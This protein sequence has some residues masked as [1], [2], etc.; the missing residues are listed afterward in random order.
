MN[1]A[2]NFTADFLFEKLS[3]R[4]DELFFAFQPSNN[5][6]LYVNDA[7]EHIWKRKRK[8]IGS[9]LSWLAE[10]IH[11]DDRLHVST[12][13]R[14]IQKDKQKKK[15]EFRIQLP[16]I[17]QKWLRLNAFLID[18]E[19]ADTI[20]GIATDITADKEY[21]DNLHKFNDK[22]NTILQILA[23]DLATPLA[24]IQMTSDL[25]AHNTQSYTDTASQKL[26]N[27]IQVSSTNSIKLIRDLL[28][29]EFLESSQVNLVMQRVDI[30]E[31]IRQII[32][33]F[34]ASEKKL[35]KSFYLLSFSKS[36]FVTI[37]EAKFMQAI[38]NLLSNALKFTRD[39]GSIMVHIEDK[40]RTFLIKVQ[41]NGI[42]IPADMQPFLFDK[43][44]KAR[45]PGIKGEP[46]VG[47]GMSIIKTIV[48]WHKGRIWFESTEGKG[49]TFFIE[50][51]SNGGDWYYRG[52]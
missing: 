6:L 37:D 30:V 38:N 42:G 29:Q 31:K 26:L 50:V 49:S 4:S 46:S 27:V 16:D 52:E 17:G 25:L 24:N 51:P 34:Q 18:K 43:F 21:S 35:R 44:T 20:I 11:P 15:L 22:K 5:L 39:D 33:Q 32:E 36:L 8:D 9:D 7:F 3:E 12:A 13:F 47:L 19:G 48:E 28:N 1:D 2:N 23:H 14:S 41:D 10:T 40:R 45:R